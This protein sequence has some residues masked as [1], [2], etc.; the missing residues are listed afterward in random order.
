MKNNGEKI[1]ICFIQT[2]AAP[3]FNKK[4]SVTYGGAEL[5]TYLLANEMRKHF[6]VDYVVGDFDQKDIEFNNNI[7]IVKYFKTTDNFINKFVKL[8]MSLFESHADIYIQR[9]FSRGT[10]IIS[11]FCLML[12]KKFVYMVAHDSE[13]DTSFEKD[14][15]I[16][17]RIYHRAA[18]KLASVILCQSDEEK[19]NLIEFKKISD[20]KIRI[21]KKGLIIPETSCISKEIDGI[22]VGRC[23]KWK[24]PELFLKL[25]H[26]NK[27]KTFCMICSSS[28]TDLL[29]FK[30][31]K[32]RCSSIPNLEFKENLPNKHVI[33]YLNN[34]KIFILTSGGEGELPMT[35]LE[36]LSCGV[37]VISV[38]INPDKILTN[39]GIGVCLEGDENQ[40]N[41]AFQLLVNNPQ[42]LME[43][44][45]RAEQ[46]I[47]DNR[48]IKK[49]ANEF[50]Q[51]LV[52]LSD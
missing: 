25:A 22:W 26:E 2:Y 49:V 6:L 30:E 32:E 23:T 10:F 37:P 17:S 20:K 33:E 18:F 47:R 13:T 43:Y 40:L 44:S 50:K 51:I 12:R 41:V 4:I 29:F 3:L 36:T 7:R 52:E 14:K 42:Q 27:N 5:Q 34:S 1:K 24:K 35:V 38:H 31:I 11:I 19:T 9:S 15:N 8:T 28:H 46:Y 21:M 48:D 16:F 39:E 45:K